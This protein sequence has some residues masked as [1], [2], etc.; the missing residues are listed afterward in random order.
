MEIK[1]DQIN[2]LTYDPARLYRFISFIFDLETAEESNAN[3]IYVMV[4]GVKINFIQT[5]KKTLDK[6]LIFSLKTTSVEKLNELAQMLEFYA[7]KENLPK[8]KYELSADRLHFYDPDGRNW[9]V[10]L[11]YQNTRLN[12]QCDKVKKAMV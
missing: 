9:E 5:E 2:L 10:K 3:S 8:P 12:C 7:Y 4:D 11:S 1:F 6:S